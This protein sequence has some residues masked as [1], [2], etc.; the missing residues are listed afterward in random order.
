[1]K[2]NKERVPLRQVRTWDPQDCRVGEG[3]CRGPLIDLVVVVVVEFALRYQPWQLSYGMRRFFKTSQ[4][5]TSRNQRFVAS[6]IRSIKKKYSLFFQ[7][8]KQYS[9]WFCIFP[10]KKLWFYI[11]FKKK[12]FILVL[13]IREKVSPD[14]SSVGRTCIVI[15]RGRVRIPTPYLFNLKK[16]N[17]NHQTNWPKKNIRKN[18]MSKVFF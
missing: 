3:V 11:F 18:W 14:H 6:F 1:L 16:L 7:K 10:Q 17:S 8:K 5:K 4:G 13:Y 9:L 15:C 12:T 2:K